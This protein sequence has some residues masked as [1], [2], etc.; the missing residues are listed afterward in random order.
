MLVLGLLLWAL[1]AL[2][3][4]TELKLET[5]LVQG[6]LAALGTSGT[7]VVLTPPYPQGR[8]TTLLLLLFHSKPGTKYAKPKG[9]VSSF[10]GGMGVRSQSVPLGTG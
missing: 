1:L 10:W 2:S 7:A 6:P 9:S 5:L 4:H 3:H 8:C